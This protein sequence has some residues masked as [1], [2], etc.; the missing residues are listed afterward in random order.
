MEPAS[1]SQ[2]GPGQPPA[3]APASN[4]APANT[5]PATARP[6]NAPAAN[7]APEPA[8][9]APEPANTAPEPANPEPA[10]TAPEPANPEPAN[11]APEPATAKPANTAP[12]PANTA[13]EPATARPANPEPASAASA[14][15]VPPTAGPAAAGAIRLGDRDRDAVAQRLQEAFAEGRLDDEEFDSRMRAALIAKLST[16]LEPLTRDLPAAAQR[17]STVSPAIVAGP[18]PGKFAI[19][20][21]SSIR[22][23]GR[24]RVP[25]RFS[26]VVYKGN[27]RL[28]LRAAE[29]SGPVTTLVTI[30]YKSHV[31]VFVPP[32]V[33]VELDGFGVSKAWSAEEEMERLLPADAPVVHI[34]GIGYKGTI[35]VATRPSEITE[36]GRRPLPE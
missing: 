9:T 19:A 23:G 25:A 21:K 13:P 14:S 16:E 27:G 29:L 6:A 26:T 30:A 34:R 11:T 10:N 3:N 22:R 24:W 2:P 28:D 20:Y 8:N 33:R 5:E 18:A 12:E 17:S 15:E 35:E 4:S 31:E 1:P 36:P 32:G 7:T